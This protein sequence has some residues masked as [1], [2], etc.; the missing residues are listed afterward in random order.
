MNVPVGPEGSCLLGNMECTFGVSEGDLPGQ[1]Y[2]VMVIAVQLTRE[3]SAAEDTANTSELARVHLVSTN[4][5]V[6]LFQLTKHILCHLQ[7]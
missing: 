7:L 5:N 6:S 1:Q 3:S 2:S 4:C